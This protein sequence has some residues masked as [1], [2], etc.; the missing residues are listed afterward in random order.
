MSPLKPIKT[1]AFLPFLPYISIVPY[2]KPDPTNNKTRRIKTL[3]ESHLHGLKKFCMVRYA[4]IIK[5]SQATF[6]GALKG[7]LEL[8]YP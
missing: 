4:K 5:R 7:V 3:Q 6:Y 1:L 2:Q 8:I